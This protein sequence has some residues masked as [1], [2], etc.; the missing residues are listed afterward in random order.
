MEEKLHNG[1][2]TVRNAAVKT[3]SKRLIITAIP[4]IHVSISTLF[5]P[6]ANFLNTN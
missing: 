2:K 6:F 1:T 3:Y 5:C 4:S